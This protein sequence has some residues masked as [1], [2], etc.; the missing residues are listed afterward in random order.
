MSIVQILCLKRQ[1]V[2]SHRLENK[3]STCTLNP[4]DESHMK[5]IGK[6]L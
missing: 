2:K 4:L 5:I 1:S 6:N 3:K